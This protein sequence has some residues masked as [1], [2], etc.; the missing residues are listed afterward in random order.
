MM[1]FDKI[2]AFSEVVYNIEWK[3]PASEIVSYCP[4]SSDSRSII[5]MM[6]APHSSNLCSTH[7]N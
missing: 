2:M 3:K 6:Y 1:F 5:S 4:G 7:Q